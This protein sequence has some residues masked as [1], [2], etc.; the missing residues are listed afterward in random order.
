MSR[1]QPVVAG[2]VTSVVGFS[3]AFAVV[4][5][6]L[7]AVG[8]SEEEAASGLMAVS[9]AM[10]VCG[11]ALSVRTRMPVHVAWS[12][13]GAALLASS[14]AVEGGWPAAIAAF[15]I[16]GL[17]IVVTGFWR[18]LAR[19][20][21]A[22]PTSVASAMLAGVLLPICL[23]PVRAL[24]EAPDLVGPIVGAW[25]VALVLWRRWAV[26]AMLVVAVVV[27]VAGQPLDSIDAADLVPPF[28]FTA[29]EL[30]LGTLVGLGLPL[31]VVTMASQN[32]AGM[33]VL[34]SFGYR[35]PL[36]PVLV[37]TGAASVATAPL[38]GH[39]VNL[40]ALSAALAAGPDAGPDLSRRWIA[41]AV[42]GVV[43]IVLGLCA[44]VVTAFFAVVPAP[45]IGTITGL[46]LLGAMTAA[47]V[48]AA[49]DEPRRDAAI[50]AFVVSASG[51]DPFGITAPFWGLL[52]GL[53]LA[54][55]GRIAPRPAS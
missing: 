52:A 32:I 45:V 20:I 22:I 23:E 11:I 15:A 14:G 26:P 43:S 39:G 53:A 49:A 41:A 2:V 13:P 42:A 29:P 12:T 9:V 44:G 5:A 54:G 27:V 1:S 38:G 46:A 34:A 35:A 6:G 17:L 25:L 47:L 10:G 7:T 18:A 36:R 33:A 55:A 3:A 19:A 24:Q 30:Q 31:F 50:V 16:A 8:A 4:L 51:I 28:A 21:E 48:A 40:A 37:A